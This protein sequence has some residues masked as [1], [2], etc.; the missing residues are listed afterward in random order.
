[1]KQHEAVIKIME[2]SGGFATLG[3]LNQNVFKIKKCDWKTKTPFASI[4]RIVQDERFFFK[5]KPGLW[6]LKSYKNKLP[7]EI[8]PTNIVSK[9][10]QEEFNH[11]YYQGLLVEIGKLKKYEAFIPSQ[12]KN[13]KFLGK[14]LGEV[15]SQENYYQFGYDHIIR[16]AKTI[17]VCWFNVRK[18]PSV[19]FEVEHSADIQNSLLKFVELQDFN[20][21][22]FIV[23]DKVRKNE[24]IGKLSLSAFVPIKSRVQFMDYDKLS[25]WH[26]KTFEIVS[27]ENNFNIQ[28]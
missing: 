16:K 13:K 21:N 4:R 5:I 2:E 24:Y 17:D 7:L 6:A 28:I 27:L 18:M 3:F 8:F 12:D 14:T 23:A 15:S 9:N 19:L 1:M 26:T 25:E 20:T 10:E 22:F 11:S